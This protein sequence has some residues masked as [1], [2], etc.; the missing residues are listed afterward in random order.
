M[1]NL[2][3]RKRKSKRKSK[4]KSK[5]GYFSLGRFNPWTSDANRRLGRYLNP[6]KKT[7][8]KQTTIQKPPLLLGGKN[9]QNKRQIARSV[10]KKTEEIKEQ[11][12]KYSDSGIYIKKMYTD[13]GLTS[14]PGEWQY[15]YWKIGVEGKAPDDLEEYSCLNYAKKGVSV[16][17][18]FK[19]KPWEV[20]DMN[21]RFKNAGPF[22]D[23]N[24]YKGWV[25]WKK[26]HP[27]VWEEYKEKCNPLCWPK[28]RSNRPPKLTRSMLQRIRRRNT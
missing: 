9:L 18:N 26:E 6:P 15:P 24:H 4:K 21:W 12:Q 1:E 7:N 16:K 25:N 20:W 17:D 27:Q 19:K 14:L 3:L 2:N 23:I 10:R 22:I 8:P 28:P 13:V 5:R 11:L